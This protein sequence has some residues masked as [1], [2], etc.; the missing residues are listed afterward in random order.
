[1]QG[2]TSVQ[3]TCSVNSKIST[4]V[5][6]SEVHGNNFSIMAIPLQRR[7][8]H[9]DFSLL[10]PDHGQVPNVSDQFRV[11]LVCNCALV[12]ALECRHLQQ[13]GVFID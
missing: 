10:T 1:M 7:G 5:S 11:K 9:A 12:F 4:L 3:L 13:G 2:L 6:M 8:T